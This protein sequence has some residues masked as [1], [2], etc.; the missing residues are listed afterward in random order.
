MHD[1]TQVKLKYFKGKLHDMHLFW[2]YMHY[3]QRLEHEIQFLAEESGIRGE[4][5]TLTQLFSKL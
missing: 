3:L 2:T 4:G 1:A 5:H